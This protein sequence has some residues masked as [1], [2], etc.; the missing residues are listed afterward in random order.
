MRIGFA[1]S[2]A[3][4]LAHVALAKA[5]AQATPVILTDQGP[6]WTSELRADYYSQDQGSKMIPLD[7]LRSLNQ[8]NGQPFLS[9][10]LARYGYLPNP[11][12]TNGLPVGFTASGPA[13]TQTVGI[14][15]SACHTR[16]ITAEGKA[17]RI[18]GGPAIVDFQGFLSD[19]DTA[20]GNAVSSEAAFASFAASVL[21]S[22]SPDPEDV[23]A[24]RK[25]VDAW[26]LRFHT[27]VSRALPMH[28]WGPGRLDAVSMIFEPGDRHGHRPAAE[29][30]D[31]GQHPAG[32]CA[33]SASLRVE[34][35][36][37]GPD[38]MVR[39]RQQR[40]RCA[41]AQPQS[42]RGLWGVRRLPAQKRR[43]GHQF[44]Q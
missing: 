18:D 11:A 27:L 17:Y 21:G 14:T 1:I 15:C 43:R 13:G 6:N 24:L 26:S 42:R 19:L 34:R 40:Q 25:E 33:G 22:H 32:G 44:P 7:W 37:T 4:V 41:R 36:D 9:D 35:A 38:P 2:L 28:P 23:S 3:L 12:N 39:L 29:P 20:V 30:A 16:Q 5:S 8:S 10:N 31:P